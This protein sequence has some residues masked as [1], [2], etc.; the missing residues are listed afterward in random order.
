[1]VKPISVKILEWWFGV[2]AGLASLLP[3]PVVYDAVREEKW[4][5]ELLL[6]AVGLSV[7]I[8][9]FWG[10]FLAVR[11][12][13]WAS[14]EFPYWSLIL[15][16][17]V[18]LSHNWRSL[19][20]SMGLIIF[21]VVMLTLVGLPSV[22]F[23]LR[24][25][26]LW[27]KEWRGNRGPGYVGGCLTAVFILLLAAGA[28]LPVSHSKRHAVLIVRGQE[29]SGLLCE[30][31]LAKSHGGAWVDPNA[32]SNS[33]EFL[34][35]V[36][37]TIRGEETGL[38]SFPEWTVVVNPPEGVEG[39][40]LLFTANVDVTVFPE[41]WD[42]DVGGDERLVLKPGI[43]VD[44]DKMAVVVRSNGCVQILKGKYAR[45]KSLFGPN[46]WKLAQQTYFLTP[47]G[48]VCHGNR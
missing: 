35:K 13:Q 20:E 30:N 36:Q 17:L 14:A 21:L 23:H 4:D 7:G 1:M 42:G 26:R 6:P 29:V 31:D 32:C 33:V 15:F 8:L 34:R 38:P 10:L 27:F 28:F 9:F 16:F 41:V 39:F 40:P 3:L 25:S 45:R 18:P 22:C 46:H 19:P 37:K 12:G 2:L 44:S 24:S 5:W 48:K 47:T 11:R 43:V